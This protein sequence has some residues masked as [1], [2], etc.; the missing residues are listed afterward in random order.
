MI[1]IGSVHTT[2]C[3]EKGICLHKHRDRNARCIAML[4]Q[5]IGGKGRFD[6]PEMTSIGKPQFVH[7]LF[8]QN[9]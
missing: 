9:F 5:S 2:F 7:K 3:E 1:H 6:S 8:V 4:F